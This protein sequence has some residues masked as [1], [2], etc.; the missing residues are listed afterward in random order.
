MVA[1]SPVS[2]DYVR[3][4]MRGQSGVVEAIVYIDRIQNTRMIQAICD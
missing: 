2:R 3:V 1:G 4:W